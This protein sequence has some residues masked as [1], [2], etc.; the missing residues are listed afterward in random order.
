VL[1][2]KRKILETRQQFN[3]AYKGLFF[4]DLHKTV[5]FFNEDSDYLRYIWHNIENF[6][7]RK[8]R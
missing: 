7:P 5:K 2:Y 1:N 6:K 3:V 4:Q 8:K